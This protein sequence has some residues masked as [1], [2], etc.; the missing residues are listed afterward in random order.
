MSSSTTGPTGSATSSAAIAAAAPVSKSFLTTALD[1]FQNFNFAQVGDAVKALVSSPVTGIEQLAN[2]LAASAAVAGVPFASTAQSLLP[3][4]ENLINLVLNVNNAAG[5]TSSTI[6]QAATAISSPSALAITAAPV[7]A[8]ASGS[9]GAMAVSGSKSIATSDLTTGL[10]ILENLNFGQIGD[11]IEQG[12][13]N[14]VVAVE[15]LANTLVKTAASAG[16]PFAQNIEN[17][18]PVADAVISFAAPAVTA[19]GG[20]TGAAA[21][22]ATAISSPKWLGAPRAT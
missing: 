15:D 2:V 9:G 12:L 11:A 21:T 10:D 3:T 1:V 5:G 17:M 14:P 8:A 7:P 16:I 13:S 19:A 6:A 22:A 20:T 4:A 18:L